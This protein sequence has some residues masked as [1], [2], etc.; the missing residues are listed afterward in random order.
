MQIGALL[1]K[2]MKVPGFKRCFLKMWDIISHKNFGPTAGFSNV[3]YPKEKIGLEWILQVVRI[4][5]I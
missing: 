4:I 3:F 2:V 5:N 1:A